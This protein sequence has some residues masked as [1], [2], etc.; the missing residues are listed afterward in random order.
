M[1]LTQGV[2]GGD[3]EFRYGLGTYERHYL[4]KYMCVFL[5]SLKN[6]ITDGI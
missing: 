2:G 6:H 1:V 3:V 4:L 5:R